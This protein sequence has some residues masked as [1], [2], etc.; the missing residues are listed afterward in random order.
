MS[1]PAR[2]GRC[3]RCY[4]TLQVYYSAGQDPLQIITKPLANNNSSDG[5]FQ[6]GMAKKLTETTTSKVPIFF[7]IPQALLIYRLG[8]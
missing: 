6:L 2:L 7:S 5:Q 3:S 8:T 4:S 1:S